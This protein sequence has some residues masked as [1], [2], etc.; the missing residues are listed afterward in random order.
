MAKVLNIIGQKFGRLTVIKR[1]DNSKQ[2]KSRWL[3]KCECGVEKI[4]VGGNLKNGSVQS[5]KCL[6]RE[7]LKDAIG[8]IPGLSNMRELIISY[9]KSA[10]RRRIKYNLSEK[11]FSKITQKDCYYCG[12]RPNNIAKYSGCNGN[13]IYNGIDRIDNKKGYTIDNIVSCCKRCN[14]AKN[15]GT[16][17][18]FFDWGKRFYNK[19]LNNENNN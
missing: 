1:V 8:L 18:E 5:C 16:L 10:K 19:S 12:T 6:Q 9:K 13:Y 4:I 15:N 7:R 11:Q 3:C 17:Q 14:M 2:G